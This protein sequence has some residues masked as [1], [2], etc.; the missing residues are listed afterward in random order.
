[1]SI[2]VRSFAGPEDFRRISDFLIE[3][4]QPGSRF[5]N[6]LQPRWEYAYCHPYFDEGSVGRMGIWEDGGRIVGVAHY[7]LRLGDSHFQVRPGYE[8]LKPAMLAY[9][10]AHL[11]SA[12]GQL[13][14]WINDFDT[15]FEAVAAAQ[16]FIIDDAGH[17]TMTALL[18]PDP[19]PPIELPAGFALQ[20]LQ[21]EN[22]LHKINRVMW[23][24]F[25]HPGEPVGDDVEIAQR[26]RMQSGPSFR[27]ELTIVVKAPE[28]TYASFCGMWYE[29]ANRF[30]YVEPVA[31][32][33]DYRRMG[34][35]KAAV[36]EG[37]RRCG[38]AGAT[39]AYVISAQPFYADMG[40][41]P[42]FTTRP[43]VKR[44]TP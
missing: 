13:T 26:K 8:H 38:A 19:F 11:V 14:A 29:T 39:V 35:G 9:A 6:W 21:E 17:E 31:T 40:F 15:E 32:D 5:S 27:K 2:H 30:A 42:L 12:E 10:Q 22:D 16:S 43:W 24:G 4:H 41:R 23:R 34:L 7:E 36:L 18:I 1:M 28:G 20:S 3:T 33:P 37:I 44:V 25:N